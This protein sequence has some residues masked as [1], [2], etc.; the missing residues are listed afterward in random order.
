MLVIPKELDNIILGILPQ[1]P[2]FGH[3]IPVPEDQYEQGALLDLLLHLLVDQ[4]AEVVLQV[5]H[6]HYDVRFQH[7]TRQFQ[8]VQRQLV[9]SAVR[10]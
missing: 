3:L 1:H 2:I 8:L 7:H 6:R 10:S 5:D 9:M 4:K